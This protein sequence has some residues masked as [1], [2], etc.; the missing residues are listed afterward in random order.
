MTRRAN[1]TS[2]TLALILGATAGSAFAQAPV[3]DAAMRRDAAEVRRLVQSGA[4]VK[5]TQADGATALHWAAYHGDASLASLLL[6]AGADVGAANRNG[7][8]PM[9]LAASHGD[10]AVIK[11]LLEKGANAN[12][13]LPLGR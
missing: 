13:Q 11:A 9:W 3:A 10:A 5:A 12:E 6:D 4:D 1:V 7:S 8:T 2:V